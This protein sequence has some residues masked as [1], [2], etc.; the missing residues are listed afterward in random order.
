MQHTNPKN[1]EEPLTIIMNWLKAKMKERFERDFNLDHEVVIASGNAFKAAL[2]PETSK[3]S[4]QESLGLSFYVKHIN[5]GDLTI[6][7][8]M[9]EI[10]ALK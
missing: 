6:D 4:Q 1:Q 7:Q 3:L 2:T 5:S 8:M 10:N 9:E